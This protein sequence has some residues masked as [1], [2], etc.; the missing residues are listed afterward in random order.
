MVPLSW[1]PASS[2][3]ALDLVLLLLL[4]LLLL[5]QLRQAWLPGVS[6]LLWCFGLSQ[7]EQELVSQ[8]PTQRHVLAAT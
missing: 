3:S 8:M 7:L 1:V 4:L 5:L 2:L 6:H